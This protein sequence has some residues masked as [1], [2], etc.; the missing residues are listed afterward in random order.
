MDNLAPALGLREPSRADGI[1]VPKVEGHGDLHRQTEGSNMSVS[2]T[3]VGI[4]IAKLVFQLHWVDEE[5]G[6][7]ASL[8][9]KRDRF[10][11]C[12]YLANVLVIAL[13]TPI[14]VANHAYFNS[15][16]TAFQH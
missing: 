8:Q 13:A 3:I 11:E 12:F 16:T 14:V 10:L 7:I 5:S 9:L 4:T 1:K 6:E 15:S 2:K